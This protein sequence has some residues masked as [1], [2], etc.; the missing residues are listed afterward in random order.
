MWIHFICLDIL[1]EWT[2]HDQ[3]NIE[4]LPTSLYFWRYSLRGSMYASNPRVVMA[5]KISSPVIVFLFSCMHRSFALW[6]VK[7]ILQLIIC[8]FNDL[9][10]RSK[11]Y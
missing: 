10:M 1:H 6:S 3:C 4:V 11:V 8:I 7:E 9:F 5:Y 2:L